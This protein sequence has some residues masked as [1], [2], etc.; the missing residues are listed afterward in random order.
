MSQQTNSF[1]LILEVLYGHFI[2]LLRFFWVRRVR[3]LSLGLVIGIFLSFFFL[4]GAYVVW[5]GEEARVHKSLEKYRSEVSNFYDSFQPKSVKILDSSGKVMGEFYRRNFRP[6]RTDNLGK[7]NVIVW[8]VLS[9]E[10]REFFSHSGL[11]YTAI[12]RAIVTNLVQ[13]RLSQGG[14]TISQQLAKL[15]LNLGK[16]N[17]F[18]KLT[19]LYCTFYIESQYS[20]E[21]ILA[22]YLNQIFLGEGNTGVEEAARYYFRK[23]ASELSP[24]EAALLVGIIPAPSVYNPV[25]NLGIALS[26]QKRVLYD[27]ARNPELHPSQKDIPN[28]FSDSIELNLKKFRTI[29]K[30][31]ENKDEEG[32]PKYSSEIGKYGADKDFRVNLAPDFNS[33]I[34]RFVLEKFSNEDLEE[35]G[36]LVYTTLDLEKQRFAEEALRVGVDSVRADLTKQEADYQSKGK[37]E[38][39]EVTRAILPQL[40]GSMISL[41]PE[42]GDVEAMVGGYKI[43]NVFR[44]NRAEDARR[45]PGSTIKALVYALAFEK[46]IVNPSSRIKDEKLDISGYSPK[47]WYKGYKGEI[48]VRQALAQ[49]VNTVSVKLLHEIGISYFVQKLSAILSIPEEEAELRFQRNLSLA[50]GS[51]ELSPM[52][53]SVIYATLMNGGR[54]VTPRKIIK[55]TDLDGNEFYNTIPNEA[56]EQILDPV[57]CAMAINTLQSVLTEEGTMTLKRKEGEPFLYAGKTG[58]VQSPKLTSSR[59]KGLKGVRDVW[60]AGLTPRNVTV[61]WV[62]HDEGAPFPGSGSGVSGGIWYKY[63]QNVKSKLGMGNQLISNFVGDFVKVDVCADDGT[64]IESTPDYICKVPLYAQYYYIGDLPPKRA[65]FA[66]QEPQQNSIPKPEL[67]DDDSEISTYDSQGSR[68][69]PTAVDSVELEPPLI[70]NRRARYNEETP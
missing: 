45:Q 19:E 12:G 58:T 42:T 38:L 35:R 55:I 64:I 23:P 49:S 11:N 27:M 1:I 62:G 37:A 68:I 61:V 34:R 48:T 24:E 8:A 39:A 21:E 40:S 32:N 2:D 28:K 29:Y 53:L 30:V 51:G 66:K 41:D 15:T 18:N 56:A 3:F 63:T 5:S 36:L 59:W 10:D 17:L 4:G 9:S 57:A 33:E 65:G 69:Q 25:R 60:F 47:N 14:S 20:K 31:K 50:L 26:R 43:S 70:E 7:H 67:I 52:E 54:R 13:F 44:F 22:M 46:R 6:I 16:R